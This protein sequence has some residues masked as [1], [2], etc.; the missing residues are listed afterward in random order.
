MNLLF[1]THNFI[2]W[3]GDIGRL[4]LSARA[5]CEDPAN[6]LFL[7]RVSIWEMQIKFQIGKLTFNQ[8]LPEIIRAQQ[9]NNGLKI[10]GIETEHIYALQ[11]LPLHHRDPF[12]RLLIAQS[13]FERMPLLSVDGAFRDYEVELLT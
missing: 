8:P 13:N 3:N 7:S 6:T 10:L 12:D 2:W 1:D 11:S 5:L 9:E 4:S